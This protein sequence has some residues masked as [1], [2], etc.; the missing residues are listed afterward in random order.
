MRPR[1][2]SQTIALL[3]SLLLLVVLG[4]PAI[5]GAEPAQPETIKVMG[6]VQPAQLVDVGAMV[7]S[8]VQRIHVDHAHVVKKGDVLATL[9]PTTFEAAVTKAKL[10]VQRAEALAGLAKA[11]LLLAEKEL[12]QGVKNKAD[13]GTVEVLKAGVD[14][15]KA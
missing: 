15:A 3:F 6:V 13:D 11:K 12:E 5:F 9:D 8:R 14:V 4:L 7:T 10:G 2:W 1:F